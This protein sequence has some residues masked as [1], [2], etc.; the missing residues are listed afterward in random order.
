MKL[1]S[2]WPHTLLFSE[3]STETNHHPGKIIISRWNTPLH[4]KAHFKLTQVHEFI[5]VLNRTSHHHPQYLSVLLP[6][7]SFYDYNQV[8]GS[9]FWYVFCINL[10]VHWF[11]GFSP[12]SHGGKANH[13]LNNCFCLLNLGNWANWKVTQQ[14]NKVSHLG[15]QVF[16]YK[17]Q[18]AKNKQTK[19]LAPPGMLG[20]L[21]RP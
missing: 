20:F 6:C 2:W 10:F 7:T 3:M 12:S 1:L 9:L 19:K 14:R 15:N 13:A 5:R 16:H 8:G 11:W 4:H 18:F 17:L 21:P